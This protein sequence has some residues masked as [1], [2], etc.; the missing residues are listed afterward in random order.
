MNIYSHIHM[1]NIYYGTVGVKLLWLQGCPEKLGAQGKELKW[2]PRGK[3]G[4]T[5]NAQLQA[6]CKL[7]TTKKKKKCHNVLTMT[8]AALTNYISSFI[9]LLHYSSEEYCDCSIR[10]YQSFKQV[11]KGPF[12]GAP[13]RLRP[14]AK[15]PPPPPLWA[16]L[17]G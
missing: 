17:C 3:E 10:V 2:S 6:S 14:G 15:S 4:S 7:K 11:L 1:Y 5:L 16:A 13:F 8:I 12:M 9:S